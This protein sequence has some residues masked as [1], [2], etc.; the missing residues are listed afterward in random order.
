MVNKVKNGG[1]SVKVHPPSDM[2][3]DVRIMQRIAW[4]AYANLFLDAENVILTGKS[5]IH[6]TLNSLSMM[7]VLFI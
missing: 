4:Q 7:L 6:E 2:P 5:L 3:S 1:S